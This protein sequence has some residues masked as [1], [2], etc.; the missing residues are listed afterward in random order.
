MSV[1]LWLLGLGVLLLPPR[2]AWPTGRRSR[3]RPGEDPALPAVLDLVAVA[4]RAGA[5]PGAALVAA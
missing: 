3:R 5:A 4:L 2:S 1:A